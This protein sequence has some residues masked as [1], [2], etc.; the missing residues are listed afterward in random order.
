MTMIPY[1]GVSY[2]RQLLEPWYNSTL[3]TLHT[4]KAGRVLERITFMGWYGRGS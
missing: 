4:F 1:R 2:V 3:E